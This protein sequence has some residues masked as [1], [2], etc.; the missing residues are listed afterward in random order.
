MATLSTVEL[1]SKYVKIKD[2]MMSYYDSSVHKPVANRNA[3]VVVFLHGNPTSNYLWRN[4]IPHVSDIARCLAPDLVG[5]GKSHR[6]PGDNHMYSYD[7]HYEYLNEWFNTMGLG[8][9]GSPKVIL[10]IHDWGSGLGFHWANNHR[11]SIAGIA[12]MEAIVTMLPSWDDFSEGGRKL[13]QSMRTDAGETIILEKNVFVERILPGSV[14]RKMLPEEL[15]VYQRPYLQKGE[16]RRPTLTWP[17]EIPVA[18]EPANVCN[19]AKNYCDWLTTTDNIPK[20]FFNATPGS[21]LTGPQRE[22]CRK[23]PNQKEIQIKG[24][25][26]VQEDAP[27]EIGAG[28]KE[29]LLKVLSGN[30]KM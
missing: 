28:V 19:Y 7:Q 21:I 16:T 20:V 24:I 6:I 18:G 14:M 11:D 1:P 15:A 4:I 23:W 27:H 3:P 9:I 5:M 22:A 12:Y 30:S 17:R 29:L 25:H 26:F 13:F 2:T 10:V 8:K